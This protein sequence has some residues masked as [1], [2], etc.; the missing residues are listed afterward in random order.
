MSVF[1]FVIVA[2]VFIALASSPTKPTRKQ[3]PRRKPALRH[4]A[5]YMNNHAP[6][7]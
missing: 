7:L 5:R 2:L 6:E 3:R 4:A 1:I